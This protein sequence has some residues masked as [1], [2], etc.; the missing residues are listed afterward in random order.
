MEIY[1][2]PGQAIL[3]YYPSMISEHVL[4]KYKNSFIAFN[5]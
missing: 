1:K 2:K 5:S 3:I 4:F